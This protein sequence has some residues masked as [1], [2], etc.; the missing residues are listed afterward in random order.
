MWDETA[1]LFG[2]DGW[3]ELSY[4]G[5]YV[6]RERIRQSLKIRYPG[7]KP[8]ESFTAH[9]ITQPVIHVAPDGL[10][11][12]IRVRLFQLGGVS[13]GSGLWLGGIYENKAALEDGTWKLTAM[14]LDYVFTAD[15]KG[16][17]A[18]AAGTF[19]APKA[20]MTSP[21]PPDRP[22]RGVVVAPF[23]K[24]VDLPF[25]YLNPVSG[26]KPPLFLP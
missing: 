7:G 13:G 21:F 6:G 15:N 26:R 9:Q 17:W 5:T 24:I 11:A 25:H 20:P 22:L 8:K 2:R 19:S 3:K 18:H 16:G 12:N 10:S 4:V 14:D 1:D 23:P